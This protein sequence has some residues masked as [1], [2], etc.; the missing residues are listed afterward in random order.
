MLEKHNFLLQRLLLASLLLLACFSGIPSVAVVPFVP[1]HLPAILPASLVFDGV[2]AVAFPVVSDVPAVAGSPAVSGSLLM[3]ASLLILASTH[4][5]PGIFTKCTNCIMRHI[6]LL[7]YRNT[8]I[9]LLCSSS[10]G[11]LEY[12]SDW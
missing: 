7:D 4:N 12:R 1:D 9:R 3:L 5:L 11:L 6:R 8:T 2:S 10:I